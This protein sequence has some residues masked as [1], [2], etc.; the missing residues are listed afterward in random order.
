VKLAASAKTTLV[1]ADQ[2]ARGDE[3]D[4]QVADALLTALSSLKAKK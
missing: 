3:V 2:W 1:K 4:T